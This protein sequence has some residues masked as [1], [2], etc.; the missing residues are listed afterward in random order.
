MGQTQSSKLTKHG[1]QWKQSEIIK[2]KVKHAQT[3]KEEEA[4]VG[5]RNATKATATKVES[6]DITSFSSA[7]NPI[8]HTAI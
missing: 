7:R 3:R 5:W 6:N 8:P 1:C 4:G 2:S